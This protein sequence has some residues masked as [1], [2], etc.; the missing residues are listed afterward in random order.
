MLTLLILIMASLFRSI[1]ALKKQVEEVGKFLSVKIKSK[2]DKFSSIPLDRLKQEREDL[3]CMESALQAS[4]ESSELK[5]IRNSL[6]TMKILEIYMIEG[7][8][9][10]VVLVSKME[11]SLEY[12]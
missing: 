11:I 10:K 8:A 2:K 9:E 6:D 3:L 5:I 7:R 1:I 4:K 12:K